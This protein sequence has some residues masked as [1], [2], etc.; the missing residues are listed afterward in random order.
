MAEENLENITEL[1]LLLQNK[2]EEMKE[3]FAV[4]YKEEEF[5]FLPEFLDR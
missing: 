4:M 5:I 1:V 3:G 2:E